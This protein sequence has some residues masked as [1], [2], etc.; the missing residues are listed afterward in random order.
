MTGFENLEVWKKASLLTIAVYNAFCQSA[1]RWLKEQILRSAL[2]V[3]SNIA[4]GADRHSDKD[5][6]NFLMI[7]RGSAAE[8][9]TQLYIASKINVISQDAVLPLIKEAKEISRMIN[10]L[11]KTLQI[12]SKNG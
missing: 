9:R 2:S 3:P 11:I 12:S 6:V 4:E 1:E 8:L 10:A 5:F 7:A